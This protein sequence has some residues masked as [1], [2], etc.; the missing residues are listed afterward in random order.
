MKIG[1]FDSGLGGLV[2]AHSLIKALPQYDYIY[3]GDTQRVPYGDRPEKEIY[4][5]TTQAVDFLFKKDCQLIIIACNT[6]FANALRK[7]QQDY[8]PNHYPKR[9]VLG[10]IIPTA[11]E[12]A[13]FKSIG[14]IATK[15]TV[16]S[17]TY[18]RELKKLNKDLTIFQQAA[19]LL[20]PLIENNNLKS[21]RPILKSYLD[22]LLSKKIK[23]IILG[24]TH[25]PLLKKQ[26]SLIVGKEI[27]II[28]Q[29]DLIPKKIKRYLENHPE[30][31]KVLSKNKKRTFYVTNTNIHYPQITKQLF[32]K[33]IKLQIVSLSSL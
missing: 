31:E 6:V 4:R 27:K 15:S 25:Y 5:F 3:L 32:G 26:I 24:C 12:A 14:I 1:I 16:R 2:I 33:N 29:T 10:V 17:Q 20:V 22:P 28:N 9:R 30:I 21:I 8:L 13:K 7:I 23:A 18:I 19:P 11:E